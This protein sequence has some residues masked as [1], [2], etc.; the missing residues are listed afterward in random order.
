MFYPFSSGQQTTS[1]RGLCGI[2]CPCPWH[3]FIY[4]SISPCVW[5]QNHLRSAKEVWAV[6]GFQRE[7][8]VD[9]NSSV[10][11]ISL[12]RG[13]RFVANVPLFFSFLGFISGQ[14][15][16]YSRFIFICERRFVADELPSSLALADE[17][18]ASTISA[19]FA[20][21]KL[22]LNLAPSEIGPPASDPVAVLAFF[23]E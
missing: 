23:R 4:R 1:E 20:R 8:A 10:R 19:R 22:D 14:L 18:S 12:Y 16:V 13:I 5:Q 7:I 2:G 11:P 17:P 21:S 15:T 6:S 3:S 9:H